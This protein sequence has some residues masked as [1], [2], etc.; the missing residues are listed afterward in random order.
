MCKAKDVIRARSVKKSF[1]LIELLIVIAIVAI[2]MA[3]LL[4]TL[5]RVRRLAKA[6][7]CQGNLRQWGLMFSMYADNN[8]HKFFKQKTGDTWIG[9]ME[10]Y[11]RN[12]KD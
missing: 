7:A 9:P 1:T 5:H 8:D 3:I 6:I 11:Y 12:C 10:P 4:P 2:L